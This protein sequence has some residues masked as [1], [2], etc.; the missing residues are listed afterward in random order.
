MLA[1]GSDGGS[2]EAIGYMEQEGEKDKGSARTVW[3]SLRVRL[4]MS[5]AR[6][7]AETDLQNTENSCGTCGPAAWG[8]QQSK[9]RPCLVFQHGVYCPQ[10]TTLFATESELRAP[11]RHSRG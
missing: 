4:I 7:R 11:D 10:T 1:L 3:L 5:V 8:V 9:Q 6:I 2:V